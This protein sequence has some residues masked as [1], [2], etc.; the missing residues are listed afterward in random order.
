MKSILLFITLLCALTLSNSLVPSVS[1]AAT[2]AKKD[3][4]MMRF[5]EPVKLMGV[6]L[7][8]DYLFVHDDEALGRGEECTFVY[9]GP[10]EIRQQLV[11]SFHCTP[12][13]RAKASHFTVRTQQ[14]FPGQSEITE[15]Q[16]AGSTAGH[17]VP[18]SQ[19]AGHFTIAGLD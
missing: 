14:L 6:T 15:Y 4:A 18:T 1:N 19:H 3:R 17:M 2:A 5:S 7:K 8:G 9:R 13:E 10:A 16:F 12:T 11:V